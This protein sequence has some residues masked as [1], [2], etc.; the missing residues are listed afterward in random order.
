MPQPG[1]IFRVL[2]ASPNDCIQE[3]KIIPEVVRAWNAIHSNDRAAIVEPVLWESHSMPE[4]GDR[5]QQLINDQLVENCDLLIGT[6]WT[7]LGTP[8][9]KALSGTAEEIEEIRAKG[10]PVLLYFS[11]APAVPDSI[12]P[13][14]YTA[15]TQYKKKLGSSGLYSTYQSLPDFREQLQNHFSQHMIQLLRK[16]SDETEDTGNNS[17]LEDENEL[18]RV[19]FVSEFEA[20]VKRLNSEWSAEKGSNPMGTDDGKYILSKAC[21]EI[22]HFK[23]LIADDTS[24]LSKAFGN[25]LVYLK[26][27]QRHK[28]YTDGGTS[29]RKF[30]EVG[31]KNIEHLYSILEQL[32]NSQND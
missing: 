32:K 2:I 25:V 4:L 27:L 31:D 8:T 14:Q 19:R 13:E 6:F 26:K 15:L 16:Y 3:R 29:F 23:G 5:P 20:F 21:D 24:D 1:L 11:S 28:T 22:I 12:D 7:R 30:W 17:N 18:A 9:G 10:K